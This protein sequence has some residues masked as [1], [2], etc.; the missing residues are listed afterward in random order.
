[1]IYDKAVITQSTI[2]WK[3]KNW[4]IVTD[5]WIQV[6]VISDNL[7]HL[8]VKA[9]MD[10][11]HLARKVELSSYRK[12]LSDQM[13]KSKQEFDKKSLHLQNEIKRLTKANEKLSSIV[14]KNLFDNEI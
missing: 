10:I 6:D 13:V 9:A 7:N 4:I 8:P 3:K 11:L 5:K 2:D 1:M 12:W 14:A